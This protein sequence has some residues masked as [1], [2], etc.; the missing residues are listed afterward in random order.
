MSN[1]KWDLQ[2][3]VQTLFLLSILDGKP[4]AGLRLCLCACSTLISTPIGDGVCMCMGT[5][6]RA[7]G[8]RGDDSVTARIK[9]LFNCS[10]WSKREGKK[11]T[12]LRLFLSREQECGGSEMRLLAIKHPAG[13]HQAQTMQAEINYFHY[14]PSCATSLP[15]DMVSLFI[16][17][18]CN[19]CDCLFV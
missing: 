18:I 4:P 17:G 10:H 16:L 6:G 11:V 3:A 7:G 13:K 12:I 15:A 14:K 5:A 8:A 19:M 9:G 1:E 2:S